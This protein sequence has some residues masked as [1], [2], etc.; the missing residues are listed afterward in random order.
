MT[1]KVLNLRDFIYPDR[2]GTDIA[3]FWMTNNLLRQDWLAQKIELRKYVFATDTRFTTNSAD[4]WKNTTTIPKMCQIRDNLIANYELNLFPK[5]KKSLTFEADT[6]EANDE[7]LRQAVLKYSQYTR[8]QDRE[9]NEYRKCIGDYVDY[10]NAFGTVEWIDQRVSIPGQKEQVGYVGPSLRRISPLDIV[11]NPTAPSFRESPKVIR[12]L[13]SLGEVK[14]ILLSQSNDQNRQEYEELFRYLR[15]IRSTVRQ[16]SSNGGSDLQGFDEAYNV[17]GFSTFQNYLQGDMVEIL[18]FYGDIYDWEKDEFLENHIITVVDRH[19]I[20]GKRPNPSFF[21]YAP[22]FHVGWRSRQDNL[23]AMGPLDNLV[24][25]QFRLDHTEN[26][27]ADLL[28]M[29]LVPPLKIKGA[30]QDAKWGPGARFILGDDGD[31]DAMTPPPQV[32]QADVLLEWYLRMMEVLAGAPQEQLG[33]RSPGEKTAFEVSKLDN[34]A[35]RIYGAKIMQFEMNFIEP[36]ENAKLELARR[37]ISASQTIPTFDDDFNFQSF[38]TLTPQDISGAGRLR[39]IA[40]RHF[41][42]QAELLQNLSNFF[43]SKMGQD[44]AIA[45]HFSGQRI[46]KMLA[47]IFGITEYNIVQPYVRLA[48][49]ADARRQ[50]QAHNEQVGM[51][52]TTPA[53]IHP[54]DHDPEVAPV[55]APPPAEFEATDQPPLGS[56]EAA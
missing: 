48:E 8:S 54:D 19:K 24:G 43:N 40:A 28:D 14:K 55:A 35:Q 30:I 45:V 51:E 56:F 9:R 31:I 53:G 12:S 46:A 7:M 34:A 21:G 38:M 25:M 17:D 15:E 20:I 37:N 33:I 3:R 52:A 11:F 16:Y 5:G 36:C 6:K 29:Y 10:G 18:T 27:K 50:A 26:A 13:V 39:P 49:E 2:L 32:L 44:P 47:E 23:W 4:P 1:G 42:E 41:A 22:I